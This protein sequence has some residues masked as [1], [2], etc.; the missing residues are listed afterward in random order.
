MKVGKKVREGKK[1]FECN[2]SELV[3]EPKRSLCVV[4]K[5]LVQRGCIFQHH[6][7]GRMFPVAHKGFRSLRLA[8]FFLIQSV[9][10]IV[11]FFSFN[12]QLCRVS[13]YRHPSD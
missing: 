2:T 3:T 13:R 9:C 4:Y 1:G 12:T 11:S 7:Y 6:T 5:K 8:I 10:V